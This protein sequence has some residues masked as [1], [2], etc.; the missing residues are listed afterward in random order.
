MAENKHLKMERELSAVLDRIQGAHP[1][2]AEGY[3]DFVE[4]YKEFLRTYRQFLGLP[5]PRQEEARVKNQW[6]P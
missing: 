2:M 5:K 6:N 4:R 3:T 1:E